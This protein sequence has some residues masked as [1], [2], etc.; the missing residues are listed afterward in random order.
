M[1]DQGAGG[2]SSQAVQAQLLEWCAAA[3]LRSNLQEHMALPDGDP[4][5]APSEQAFVA[6][7]EAFEA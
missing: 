2:V 4:S 1:A 6:Q 5:A 3:V 7:F